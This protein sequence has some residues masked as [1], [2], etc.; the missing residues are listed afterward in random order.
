MYLD[1]LDKYLDELDKY[2]DKVKSRLKN[3]DFKNLDRDKKKVDL[4]TKDNLNG[5]QKL[6]LTRWTFSISI[7]IG[8]HRRDPQP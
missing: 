2:L 3:L 1:D 4:N 7:S 6:V 5:F 8:L